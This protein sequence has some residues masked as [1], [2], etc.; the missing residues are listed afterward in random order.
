MELIRRRSGKA[1]ASLDLRHRENTSV[2]TP[3]ARQ[4]LATEGAEV[5]GST[6]E[7]FKAYFS[8]ETRKWAKIMKAVG[9]KLQ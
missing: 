9:I 4:H 3:D 8:S 2:R 6:P 7:Q 1:G 5:V